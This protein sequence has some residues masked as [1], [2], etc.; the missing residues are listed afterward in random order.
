M[1]DKIPR[2]NSD[3]RSNLIAYLDGELPEPTAKEIEHVLS[4]SPTVQHDVE[5]LSRTWDLLDQLPRLTGSSDLTTRMV[6]VVKAADEPESICPRLLVRGFPRSRCV[7]GD[8]RG[9]GGGIGTGGGRRWLLRDKPD[10]ARSIP[11]AAEGPAGDRKTR[12]LLECR[13]NRILTGI[14]QARRGVS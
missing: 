3:Q 11:G 5:M 10:R 7:A 13:I 2:L 1:M 14:G 6:S 4:R 8:C 9:L 12:S